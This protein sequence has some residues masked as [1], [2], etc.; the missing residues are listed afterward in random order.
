[1]SSHP[2][3]MS[4]AATAITGGLSIFFEGNAVV[5][6]DVLDLISELYL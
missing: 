5:V 4:K 6:S 3:P 2:S 1:M